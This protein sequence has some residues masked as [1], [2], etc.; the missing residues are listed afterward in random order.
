MKSTRVNAAQINHARY[1]WLAMLLTAVLACMP[2]P[3][4]AAGDIVVVVNA[5]NPVDSLDKSDVARLFLGRAKNFPDGGSATVV[6][7]DEGN[8]TRTAFEKSV[9]GK[10][11]SQ[12]KAYW[13]KQMFSGQGTPPDS[14]GDDAAVKAKVASDVSAIGYIPA[15]MVDDSVKVVFTL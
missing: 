7:S 14:V 15:S 12:M 4:A 13:A 3:S 2:L 5:S 11:E 8:A 1:L 6:T 9:L 10:S